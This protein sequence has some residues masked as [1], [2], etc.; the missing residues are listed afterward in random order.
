MDLIETAIV[1]RWQLKVR[2][3]MTD[4]L[5]EPGP[6]GASAKA[7]FRAVVT[8]WREGAGRLAMCVDYTAACVR[9]D[10]GWKFATVTALVLPE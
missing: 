4:V 9:T 8:D 2:H 7:R 3:Q 6:D 1:G 5:V 10:D